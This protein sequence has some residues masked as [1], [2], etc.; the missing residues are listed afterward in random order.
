MSTPR[1]REMAYWLREFFPQIAPA[2]WNL[3]GATCWVAF[4][5]TREAEHNPP[6]Y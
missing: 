5:M 6:F 1:P 4:M 3:G 2:E